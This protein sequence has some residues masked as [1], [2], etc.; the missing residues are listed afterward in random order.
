VDWGRWI[1]DCP[2]D[3]CNDARLVTPGQKTVACIKGH[4]S[5]VIWPGDATTV[6][7]IM[8]ALQ[9]RPDESKQNWFPAGSKVAAAG[10]YPVDQ[11]PA[12]LD[13]ETAANAVVTAAEDIKRSQ[14][15]TM[16]A[17]FGISVADD[18]TI[19]GKV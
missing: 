9:K 7:A 13:A 3:G 15:V 10:G 8:A 16:L 17:D 14:L 2:V 12:D 1:V 19:Q 4:L 5:T 18:G 6:T 11:T